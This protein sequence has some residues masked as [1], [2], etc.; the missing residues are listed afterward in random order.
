MKE[1]L[2]AL[3]LPVGLL[4]ALVYMIGNRFIIKF[5]DAVAYPMFIISIALMLTGIAYKSYRLGKRNKS[6]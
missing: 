6:K 3:S 1:K 4:I 2:L 5:P